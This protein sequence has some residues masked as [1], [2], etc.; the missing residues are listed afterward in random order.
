MAIG[1]IQKGNG[2]RGAAEYDLSK[3]LLLASNMVGTTPRALA[4]E[5]GRIRALRPNLN[6]PV[7]HCSVSL[8]PGEHLSDADM[9]KLGR[10]HMRNMGLDPDLHQW[11]ITRHTD[12]P[13]EHI[14]I[15]ANRI[16]LDGSVARDGNDYQK[17]ER[18]LRKLEKLF[19][20]QQVRC[21]WE[22]PIE[23]RRPQPTK[24][25]L[26]MMRRTGEASI[27]QQMV[28][29]IDAAIIGNPT[30][31]MFVARLQEGGMSV[32]PSLQSV[33]KV[34]G[35]G[36]VL[37]GEFMKGS[38]LASK[39]Y[40]WPSL[41]K[42]GLD[43][44]RTRDSET[45]CRLFSA[46]KA[47]VNNGKDGPL[48]PGERPGR[49]D[50][51]EAGRGDGAGAGIEAPTI[52]SITGSHGGR[53]DQI[54]DG[55]REGI[56]TDV[57]GRDD[58]GEHGKN[59]HSEHA[60]IGHGQ[61]AGRPGGGN[62]EGQ[63][64]N[65]SA[66]KDQNSNG[67]REDSTVESAGN[68]GISV[69]S[70]GGG[71]GDSIDID[72][73]PSAEIADLAA[74]SI[75]ALGTGD[76]GSIPSDTSGDIAGNIG[77]AQ[78]N[79][80]GAKSI[81]DLPRD[82]KAKIAAWR[83]QAGALKAEKYRIAFIDRRTDKEDFSF[84]FG[85]G[86]AEDGKE[87]FFTEDEIVDLIPGFRRH[88]A[89]GFDVYVTPIS[90]FHHY[91]LC[92]D[93]TPVALDA[94]LKEGFAPC[95]IQQSSDSN[96]QAILM[97]EKDVGRDHKEEQSLA[98]KVV[99]WIN[100]KWG[101]AKLSGVIHAFRMAGFSNKKLGKENAFTRPQRC[102]AGLCQKLNAKLIEVRREY[103]KTRVGAGAKVR[104]PQAATT[105][106]TPVTQAR[107]ATAAAAAAFKQ[108]MARQVYIVQT[109]GWTLNQ[110]VIDFRV[111]RAMLTSGFKTDEIHDAMAECSPEIETRHTNLSHYIEATIQ[112]AVVE[113][114]KAKEQPE[115]EPGEENTQ[116][117]KE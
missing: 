109:K 5:F 1:D 114:N 116:A 96:Q 11:C 104:T 35:I 73:D 20:L 15:L 47:R 98:N 93:M 84:N 113:N 2:F 92:D 18:S 72:S 13:H 51:E 76:S 85:K 12:R 107:R 78:G 64:S 4:K 67:Q 106:K 55:D 23:E 7:W 52:G 102:I 19:H 68:D 79:R 112:K 40:S 24:G 56:D 70:N 6:S 16:G 111:A 110:S 57:I 27:K 21:S 32:A 9:V 65:G 33:D 31:D 3:G 58:G 59:D 69:A 75:S 28:A 99:Q 53:I 66:G 108:Q 115:D 45:A 34:F 71:D 95:L 50:A 90:T 42:K 94:M 10:A 14:H 86:K 36:F 103:D 105:T 100:Q 43:Y 54:D 61:S 26:G 8:P 82:A 17:Q 101:D 62:G 48:A 29:L 81:A 39:G 91:V 25:E 63:S 87:L 89:R 37:D 44:E 46:E 117:V 97:I 83:R 41:L 49:G 88:N 30:F 38:D 77:Q 22:V 80:G 60:G 74:P